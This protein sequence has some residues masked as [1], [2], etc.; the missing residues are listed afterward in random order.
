MI[1]VLVFFSTFPS[2]PLPPSL[3]SPSS[4][5]LPSLA[6]PIPVF[7][8]FFKVPDPVMFVNPLLA[9]TMGGQPASMLERNGRYLAIEK[10]FEETSDVIYTTIA[11]DTTTAQA[12]YNFEGSVSIAFDINAFSTTP[13]ASTWG[14][15]KVVTAAVVHDGG[16]EDTFAL[17]TQNCQTCTPMLDPTVT[18][19]APQVTATGMA[20]TP[21]FNLLKAGPPA[22]VPG[23][24]G[25]FDVG[26][27]IGIILTSEEL[28]SP[29][30]VE[31]KASTYKVGGSERAR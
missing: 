20:I 13:P 3:F 12:S 19:S 18:L 31:T 28:M 27:S 30:P 4:P 24:G 7:I 5:L 16:T 29:I 25:I 22:P 23:T 10:A 6:P 21:T 17:L 15:F 9:L 1:S 11:V 14:H 2:P 26:M 8:G